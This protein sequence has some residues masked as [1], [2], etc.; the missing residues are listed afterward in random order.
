MFNLNIAV[1]KQPAMPQSRLTRREV[2]IL[3]NI[4]ALKIIELVENKR[5]N[6]SFCE[7]LRKILEKINVQLK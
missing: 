3:G 5:G 7:K 4:T 1:Q 2:M 6:G